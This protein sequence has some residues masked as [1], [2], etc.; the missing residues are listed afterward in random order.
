VNLRTD[1]LPLADLIEIAFA[2]SM[3]SSGRAALREMR[4]LSRMGMGLS[5]LAN[6]NELALGIKFGYVWIADG[7]L[8]GNVSIYPTNYP[9]SLGKYWIIANVGVH[10]DYQR[11]GIARQLMRASMDFL[12][13]QDVTAAILQVD[14]DNFRAHNLYTSLDFIDERTWR[15]WRRSNSARVSNRLSE[16]EVFISRR[17]SSD[18]SVEYDLARRLRPQE[19]GGMGWLRPLQ[20]GLFRQSWRQRL[21]DWL[22]IR[23]VERLVVMSQSE[24]KMLASLWIET[25]LASSSSQLMLM[26]EPEYHGIYDDALLNTA[27]RRFGGD[28]LVIEHPLDE[29]VTNQVLEHY[30]FTPQRTVVHMRWDVR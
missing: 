13:Q 11:R 1:L 14:H 17:R 3:D 24:R 15:T 10:P 22:N 19:R 6:L 29:T 12:R 28:P 9:R 26:V 30:R 21:W 5:L 25:S 8:V 16:Q 2:D 20:E 23:S 4:Y 7:K 18:W 27:V